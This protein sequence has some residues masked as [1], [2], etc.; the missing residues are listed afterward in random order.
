[1]GI[2]HRE[3]QSRH[4]RR[5]YRRDDEGQTARQE[6]KEGDEVED[7]GQSHRQTDR[8]QHAPLPPGGG[9]DDGDEHAVEHEPEATPHGFG[10]ERPRQS[11]Q[12]SARRPAYVGNEAQTEEV[13]Y[14]HLLLFGGGHGEDLVGDA[15]G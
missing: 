6:I 7:T 4:R 10:E 1:M 3:E 9:D 5:R 15:E 8:E 13:V 14:A 2:G 12:Q 11:T